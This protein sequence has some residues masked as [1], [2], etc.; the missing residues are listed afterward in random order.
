M[1]IV[2]AEGP[3][4]VINALTLYSVMQLNLIPTGKHAASDGRNPAVQFFYN[5]KVLAAA[6]GQQAAIL[7]GMLFTLLIWVISAISLIVACIFYITF[8]WHHIPTSDGSLKKFCKRKIDTRLHKIVSVNNHKALTQNLVPRTKTG[9]QPAPIRRQPT[10]PLVGDEKTAGLT[11]LSR[12]TT[13]ATLPPYA[14]RP[15]TRNENP[16]QGI[17]RQP[18]LPDLEGGRPDMPNRSGTESS[19]FSNASYASD[20]PLI[21]G[22]GSMGYSPALQSEPSLPSLPPFR[23]GSNPNPYNDRPRMNRSATGASQQSQASNWAPSP[24]DEGRRTPGGLRR[25]QT[26]GFNFNQDNGD[27][28]FGP[29]KRQYTEPEDFPTQ[30]RSTPGPFSSR[31]PTPRQITPVQTFNAR[32]PSPQASTLNPPQEFEMRPRTRPPPR[33]NSYIPYQPSPNTPSV[34]ETHTAPHRNLTSPAWPFL[35]S[36]DNPRPYPPKRSGTAPLP[37]TTPYD[38]SIYDSYGGRDGQIGESKPPPHSVPVRAATAIGTAGPTRGWNGPT[39]APPPRTT[40]SNGPRYI[41]SGR[42]GAY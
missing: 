39:N 1:R 42:P 24:I 29:P 14:S 25:Q 37:Q 17:E 27:P 31:Q 22:A 30:R 38:A 2:F 5:L 28:G 20:A 34:S 19:A 3:R 36:G 7:L 40:S 9:D 12:Q 10:I 33:N 8:L 11:T 26:D 23:T 18:T 41:P 4:N 21:G 16:G 35:G 15:P 13:Q 6:N 32:P